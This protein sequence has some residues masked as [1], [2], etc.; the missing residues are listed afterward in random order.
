MPLLKFFIFGLFLQTIHKFLS[1]EISCGFVFTYAQ[2]SSRYYSMAK[3]FDR[4]AFKHDLIS[5]I[6]LIQSM[7][8]TYLTYLVQILI[9]IDLQLWWLNGGLSKFTLQLQNYGAIRVQ[10]QFNKVIIIA[11][12]PLCVLRRTRTLLNSSTIRYNDKSRLVPWYY[13]NNWFIG[14]EDCTIVKIQYQQTCTLKCL[15]MTTMYLL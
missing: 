6:T 3:F 4:S 13:N 1:M 9:A 5:F 11:D 10:L 7:L 15:I 12:I 8:L 2:F 14:Y